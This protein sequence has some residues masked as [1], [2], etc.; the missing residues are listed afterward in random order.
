[1]AASIESR[2]QGADIAVNDESV[3]EVK[4]TL[5]KSKELKPLSE[6]TKNYM[7]A[8]RIEPSIAGIYQ[9]QAATSSSISADGVTIG[10]VRRCNI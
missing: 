9:A 8:N 7:V 3:A 5:E 1:M 2:M 10:K 4:G 6:N